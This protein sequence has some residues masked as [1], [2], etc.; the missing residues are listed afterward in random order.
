[1]KN[2]LIAITA[3]FDTEFGA[4]DNEKSDVA[5]AYDNLLYAI[6]FVS[7]A[8]ALIVYHLSVDSVLYPAKWNTVF[9]ALWGYV[10]AA[11]L[12][13]VKYL[14]TREYA[15]FRRTLGIINRESERLVTEKS[16]GLLA[17]DK[18]AK[19]IMSIL[20]RS[21]LSQHTYY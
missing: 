8:S 9:R 18:S 5:N 17:G 2:S 19:D 4:L 7:T 15:R 6:L 11:L 10:P 21:R 1:M 13:F 3:G 16:A 12:N 20:G 14:P